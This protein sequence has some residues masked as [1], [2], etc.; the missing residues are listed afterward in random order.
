M[1]IAFEEAQQLADRAL[2]EIGYQEEDIPTIRDHLLDSELR[3]YGI[4]GLARIL[5]IADRLAGKTPSSGIEVTSESPTTAQLNG[6]DTLGYLVAHKATKVAIEKA[7]ACGVSAVGANNTY[8][9][10]MLSYYAEMAAAED[11]VTIIASNCSPWVAPQGTYKPLVGTNPF[12]IGVPTDGVPIIYDIGTSRI[13][14]AQV[15]LAMRKNEQLPPDTAFDENG[16][17]TTDP[18]KALKG[19]LAV[20]GGAKGSGLAIAVQLLGILAGSPALPPNLEEFGYFIMAI[21]P[22]KFRPMAD[23][24]REVG[25]LITAFHTTPTLPGHALRLPFERSNR[26]R[27]ETRAGGYL[28]V[29]DVVIERLEALIS[30]Q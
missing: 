10:G 12:C 7:K 3:G 15:M 20:W 28:E 4:A 21:D 8:Y 1:K 6:K 25:N 18:E 29:D 19:A 5:S 2:R 13:I 22:A 27:A 24:K 26:R 23:F 30:P 11:L 16:E 9:T 14:H 17:M